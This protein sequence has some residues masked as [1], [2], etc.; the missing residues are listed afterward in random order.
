MDLQD[1]NSLPL[2]EVDNLQS[3]GSKTEF[4]L[5]YD[6]SVL[7]SFQNLNP[8][9]TYR[10]KLVCPEFTALC[11]KTGQPDFGEITIT[12]DPDEKLVE[13]KSLKLYLGGFR[14][15]G[16]FHED[17]INRIAKDLIQLLEPKQMLVEGRFASRGGISI[18]PAVS[19]VKPTKAPDIVVSKRIP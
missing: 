10:V 8:D 12:Y 4:P 9:Q 15:T 13:S 14:N 2:S 18:N 19:Y 11:P 17:V 16:V 7:E 6:P 3:L 5:E 1:K